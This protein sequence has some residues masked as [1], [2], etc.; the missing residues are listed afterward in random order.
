VPTLILVGELDEETPVA[1]AQAIDDLLPNSRMVVI[2]GA[3][4]LLN[5]EAPE[6]VNA[7]MLEHWSS[8][9]KESS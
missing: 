9:L 7:L 3:G 1:Y 2:P 8:H 5:L 6:E 4:H